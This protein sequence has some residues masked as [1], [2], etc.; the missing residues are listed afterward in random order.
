MASRR[1]FLFGTAVA[2]N[3]AIVGVLVG[4]GFMRW[5]A[6]RDPYIPDLSFQVS[7]VNAQGRTEMWTVARQSPIREWPS[8]DARQ[9][10]TIK[11]GDSIEVDGQTTLGGID[12]YR[13]VRFGGKAGFVESRAIVNP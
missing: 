9:V 5:L 6:K 7:P 13:V 8:P 10:G 2:I 11:K 12:W 1:W 3:F 4:P